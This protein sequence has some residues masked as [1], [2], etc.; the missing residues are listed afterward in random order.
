MAWSL[1]EGCVL[2][3]LGEKP[4]PDKAKSQ[5]TGEPGCVSATTVHEAMLFDT[6]DTWSSKTVMAPSGRRV[7]VYAPGVRTPGSIP[8]CRPALRSTPRSKETPA[9]ACKRSWLVSSRTERHGSS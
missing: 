1:P 5:P 2:E 9:Q 6:L 7:L 4:D 3:I 8:A